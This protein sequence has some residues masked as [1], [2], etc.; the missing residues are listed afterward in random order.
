VSTTAPSQGVRPAD[1]LP[2][3][4]RWL[5]VLSHTDPRYGGLSS[6][7]P[8][9]AQSVSAIGSYDVS[10]AAFCGPDEHVRPAGFDEA[11]LSFWPTGRGAWLTSADLRRQ[12]ASEVRAADG[13][14]IHGL[15]EASTAMA[16]RTARSLGKPYIVSAHGMLEPW[17]LH[18]KRLKKALYAQFIEHKVISGAAC[19]HAL[20]HAEA[21]QYRA[22]GAKVPIAVIPNAVDVPGSISPELFFLRFPKL[23]NRRIVLFLGRLHPKKGLDLLAG[24]WEKIAG[25]HPEAH[26][27]IAGPDCEGTKDRLGLALQTAGLESSVTF[28]GMLGQELKWSALA[29]AEIFT[30]PSYSEGLSMGALEAMGAGLPVVVTRNCNM[31]EVSDHDA[32]WEIDA[33]EASLTA[34]LGE[35]LDQ[36]PEKNRV[37][38]RRGG[39]LITSRYNS[40]HVARAM[41]EVY[42]YVLKGISPRNVELC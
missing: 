41:S 37:M 13:I 23:R 42:G 3:P 28:A 25:R 38:G 24:S 11:H 1:N 16:S 29:A 7:V 33:N 5:A 26:L 15:W 14:H 34:A 9:L 2:G 32:G 17:A 27:V 39:D 36:S 21:R 4:E 35:A 10:L 22:F 12:F 6:A 30:L 19:L 40:R 18:Q 20:T 31:P 8:R